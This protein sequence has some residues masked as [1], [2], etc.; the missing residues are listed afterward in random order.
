[1][2][3]KYSMIPDRLS[4]SLDVTMFKMMVC[5]TK[6]IHSAF[7]TKETSSPDRIKELAENS[8]SSQQISVSKLM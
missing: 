5:G 8:R 4:L 2:D 6:E 7:V 1:M 3:V